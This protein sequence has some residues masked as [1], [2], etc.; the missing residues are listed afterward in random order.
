MSDDHS[1]SDLI[2]FLREVCLGRIIQPEQAQVLIQ[3]QLLTDDGRVDPS[4]QAVVLSAVRGEGKKLHIISPFT[5]P[6][7]RAIA[8]F[9]NARNYIRSYTDEPETKAILRL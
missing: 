4:M 7:D 2:Y 3:E 9:V 6:L 5:D 1:H 8:E